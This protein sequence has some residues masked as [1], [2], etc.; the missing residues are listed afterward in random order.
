MSWL[1]IAIIAYFLVALEVILDKFML[2]SK[3]V[4]HPA[5]YAFYSGTLSLFVLAFIP[6]GVHWLPFSQIVFSLVSGAIF[7]YGILT[8]FFA[9]KENEASQV[10][11]VVGAMIP[12]TTF[13]L[14]WAFIGE[15]L[16]HVQIWG[17]ALLILGGLLISFDLPFHVSKKKFFAGFKLSLL[18]GF[19]LAVAFTAF[20]HFFDKNNFI[21]VF[22]WT[23]F[24]LFAGAL[25][26]FLTPAW[27]K[28][29][30]GSFGGFK[31]GQKQ[32]ENHRT[33]MLFVLNKILGGTGSILTNYAIKLGSV[34]IVNAL[35]ALEYGFIFIFGL[36][37]SV[38]F[39][40]V[41]KEKKGWMHLA[42]KMASIVIITAGI[43]MV[44]NGHWLR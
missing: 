33:G 23:R 18:A 44:S 3:R 6:F 29:I 24:G 2:S 42:Q 10:M 16:A 40:V 4:S 21:T 32:K 26:L 30:L 14:S 34:T 5:I 19:L 37:F 41:F 35:V 7:T 17:V 9:I 20:K 25:S 39:P 36:F 13:F 22:T 11:P 31:G 15:R 8:L 38:W 12:L 1:V 43:V 27:R 28:V